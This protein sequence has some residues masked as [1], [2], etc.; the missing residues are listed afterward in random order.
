MLVFSR[1]R[2]LSWAE[3][4]VVV[5]ALLVLPW[6]KMAVHVVRVDRL[7][8]AGVGG[9]CRLMCPEHAWRIS[10]VEL[11]RTHAPSRASMQR[12]RRRG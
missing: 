6:A 4:R 3:R 10:C 8:R 1:W 2:R 12:W 9:P 5:E 7:V 11:P